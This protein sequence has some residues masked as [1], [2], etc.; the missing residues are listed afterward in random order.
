MFYHNPRRA[1]YE[2]DNGGKL[3]PISAKGGNFYTL[4]DSKHFCLANITGFSWNNNLIR[5]LLSQF[6][7]IL[8]L[9]FLF[10]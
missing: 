3:P 5:L 2:G 1:Y 9:V 4:K 7:V 10:Y 6:Y 8:V